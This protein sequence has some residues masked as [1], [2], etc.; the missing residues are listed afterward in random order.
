MCHNCTWFFN[1]ALV[2]LTENVLIDFLKNVVSTVHFS[3][4]TDAVPYF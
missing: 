2:N 4:T 1:T 3:V